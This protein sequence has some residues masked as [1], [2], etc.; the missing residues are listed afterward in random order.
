MDENRQHRYH[1]AILLSVS[2][3]LQIKEHEEVAGCT[4]AKLDHLHGTPGGAKQQH[5]A[6]GATFYADSL[7]HQTRLFYDDVGIPFYLP[8]WSHS[9]TRR[10]KAVHTRSSMVLER[11]VAGIE[12]S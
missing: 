10:D 3:S 1:V 7:T 2:G 6:E 5:A 8:K 4:H 11:H 9:I 12:Q